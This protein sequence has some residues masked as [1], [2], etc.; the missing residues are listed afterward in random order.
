MVLVPPSTVLLNQ[1]F[2]YSIHLSRS[3]CIKVSCAQ[4]S[5]GIHSFMKLPHS[6]IIDTPPGARESCVSMYKGN[7]AAGVCLYRPC[8]PEGENGDNEGETLFAL[9]ALGW[10]V[11]VHPCSF[12][13][14]RPPQ[15]VTDVFAVTLLVQVCVPGLGRRGPES[16]ARRRGRRR[17]HTYAG[18]VACD[19]AVG[20]CASCHM[21]GSSS[22]NCGQALA[23][24]MQ[25]FSGFVRAYA[26]C[27]G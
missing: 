11:P 3:N 7:D 27:S 16:R 19:P 10:C 9:F 15:I 1:A 26:G 14:V 4:S 17:S 13:N 5:C 22:R 21:S 12:A 8:T 25:C 20:V 18:P 6:R 24:R 2:T 23:A